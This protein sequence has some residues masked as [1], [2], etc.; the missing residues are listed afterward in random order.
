MET[1]N[2]NYPSLASKTRLQEL[3][4]NTISVVN[5]LVFIAYFLDHFSQET[6]RRINI[7]FVSN[8]LKPFRTRQIDKVDLAKISIQLTRNFKV[9]NKDAMG[10]R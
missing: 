7:T 2:S 8:L 3:I 4:E 9:S 5:D 6:Q 10:S 1:N